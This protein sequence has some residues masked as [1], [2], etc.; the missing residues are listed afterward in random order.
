MSLCLVDDIKNTGGFSRQLSKLGSYYVKIGYETL[1][2]LDGNQVNS[3]WKRIWSLS[4]TQRIRLFLWKVA[5]GKLMCNEERKKMHFTNAN[6]CPVC[7]SQVETVIHALRDCSM[8]KK[9]WQD[10]VIANFFVAS[11][12]RD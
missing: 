2:G 4:T 12:I 8:A 5:H 1:L 7:K 9:F 6:A 3:L 10:T 11:E